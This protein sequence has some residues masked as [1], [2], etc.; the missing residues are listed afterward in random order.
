MATAA[1]FAADAQRLAIQREITALLKAAPA[2]PGKAPK[3]QC[4]VQ[5]PSTGLE[6]EETMRNIRLLVIFFS[7]L[8][9]PAWAVIFANDGLYLFVEGKRV[10]DNSVLVSSA[11]CAGECLVLCEKGAFWLRQGPTWEA[12]PYT[13]IQVAGE[14]VMTFAN[15]LKTPE[16]RANKDVDGDYQQYLHGRSKDYLRRVAIMVPTV[17]ESPALDKTQNPPL[18]R[19][20][21]GGKLGHDRFFR[22]DLDC[23][24]ITQV[25]RGQVLP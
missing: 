22:V 21:V 20:V 12:G 4:R 7:L 23:S 25:V 6:G 5:E 17:E 3:K 9:A 10:L 2:L 1:E 18:S 16:G 8:V 11:S 24:T 14:E 13:F 19:G 15:W